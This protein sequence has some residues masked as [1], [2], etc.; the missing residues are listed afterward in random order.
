MTAAMLIDQTRI[1]AVWHALSG[2]DL[3]RELDRLRSLPASTDL[4][5]ADAQTAKSSPENET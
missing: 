4:D 3:Q 1:S 5:K 2:G